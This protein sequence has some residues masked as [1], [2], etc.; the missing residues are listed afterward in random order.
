MKTLE[1]E[2]SQ[3]QHQLE[4]ATTKSDRQGV[5]TWVV[6]EEGRTVRKRRHPGAHCRSQLFRVEATVSDVHASRLSIGSS[7]KVR[8]NDTAQLAGN[9]VR[10]TRPWPMA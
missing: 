5:L 10:V 2:L 3:A 7:V 1:R 9:I 4:V 6:N 8:I